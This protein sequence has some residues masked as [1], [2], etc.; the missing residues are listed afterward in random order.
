MPRDAA[1][2]DERKETTAMGFASFHMLEPK[3]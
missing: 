2:L 1:D 3:V